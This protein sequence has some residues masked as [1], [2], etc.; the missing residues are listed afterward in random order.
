[1]SDNKPNS[2]ALFKNDKQGNENRPDYRG[3]LTDEN[4]VEKEVSAWLKTSKSGIKYMSIQVSD[5]WVP[6]SEPNNQQQPAQT[7]PAAAPSQD[8]FDDDI[9]F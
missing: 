4:G 1:M 3:P 7:A 8:D 6:K 2:G 9:P 5:K